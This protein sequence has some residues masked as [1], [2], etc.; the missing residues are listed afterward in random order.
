[1]ELRATD[2]LEKLKGI[3]R[4][5]DASSKRKIW[6]NIKQPALSFTTLKKTM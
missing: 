4:L 2:L 1:M 5:T 3:D 6:K